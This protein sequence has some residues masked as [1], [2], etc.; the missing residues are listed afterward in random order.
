MTRHRHDQVRL[1]TF[2]ELGVQE[3]IVESGAP[4]A[5]LR[6][7]D[8]H[9]PAESVVA[10]VRRGR[11]ILVPHGDTIVQAGDVL[12]VVAGEQASDEVRWLCQ[13]RAAA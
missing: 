4:C 1:S 5:G 3:F 12:V 2:S 7:M 6:I 9:W 10:S 11:R 8:V 13:V